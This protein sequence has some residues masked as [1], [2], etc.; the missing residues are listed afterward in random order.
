LLYASEVIEL[1]G[2]Y[3]GRLFKMRE[4]VN[5]VRNGRPINTT[6]REALRKGIR[7]VMELLE[8]AGSVEIHPSKKSTG[9][10]ASYLWKSGT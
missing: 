10:S 4:L 2:A 8:M 3:P 9:G 5:Y 7:R 6:Q 1:M